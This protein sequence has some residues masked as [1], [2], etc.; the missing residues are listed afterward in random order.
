MII[1]IESYNEEDQHRMFDKIK[2]YV[3]KNKKRKLHNDLSEYLNYDIIILD[4]P[5]ICNCDKGGECSDCVYLYEII[6]RDYNHDETSIVFDTVAYVMN[7][8]GKTI[9]KIVA[10]HRR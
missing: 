5:K 1:K 6:C 10:N 8:N 4:M 9:E 2:K 7:D 3:L